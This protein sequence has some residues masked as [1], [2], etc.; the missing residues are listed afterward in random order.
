MTR[1]GA[2]HMSMW[3]QLGQ[4]STVACV[5][6]WSVWR[7][8]R[9]RAIRSLSPQIMCTGMSLGICCPSRNRSLRVCLKC[10]GKRLD[11]STVLTIAAAS[12]AGTSAGCAEIC[13][14][15]IRRPMR[16]RNGLVTILSPR[17]WPRRQLT[18]RMASVIG[19]ECFRH[20]PAGVSAKT[21][22][23]RPSLASSSAVHPPDEWPTT[24]TCSSPR[25]SRSTATSFAHS[26][27]VKELGDDCPWAGR[28]TL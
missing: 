17:I 13:R 24:A 14:S 3:P 28:S 18:T 25:W 7:D 8:V 10:S 23:A 21:P 4:V 5:G 20:S 2:S 16:V 27:G 19:G 12:S 11:A 15:D 1:C 22:L 6:S 9:A 26:G